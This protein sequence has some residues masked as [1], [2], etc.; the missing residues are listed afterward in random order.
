MPPALALAYDRDSLVGV[1]EI[2]GQ[3]YINITVCYNML[4][5]MYSIVIVYSELYHMVC[6]SIYRIVIVYFR[7]IVRLLIDSSALWLKRS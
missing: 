2:Q 7:R 1:T 4:Q 3:S 6:Y 5:Y